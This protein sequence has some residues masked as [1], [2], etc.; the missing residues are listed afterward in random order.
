MKKCLTVFLLAM[1]ILAS[2]TVAEA[3]HQDGQ[4]NSNVESRIEGGHH[5]SIVTDVNQIDQIEVGKN[6]NIPYGQL[7]NCH[8]L[9]QMENRPTPM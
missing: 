2:F 9:M 1:I 5:N 4:Q 7:K 8:A 6:G 3:K